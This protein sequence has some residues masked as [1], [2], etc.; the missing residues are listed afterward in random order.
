MNTSPDK[1]VVIEDAPKGV[2]AAKNAG[3]FCI[4]MTTT[5]KK[6]ILTLADLIV[7]S[8]KEINLDRL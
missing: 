8:Y 3:M 5:F 7:D 1:Y 6:D 2:V 4:G